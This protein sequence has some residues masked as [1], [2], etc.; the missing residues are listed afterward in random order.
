MIG[1]RITLLGSHEQQLRSWLTG[2]PFGHERGAI[3]LFR[4]LSRP[5]K[6]LPRS[7]R[8]LSVEI[9]ELG[10]DWVLESS[11]TDFTINMRKFPEIYF[12][13]E[14]EQLELGFV[15]SHPD[16]Y[17]DFSPRDDANEKNILHG[18][19]GCNNEKSF[20]VSLILAEGK[21][22]AR[23][24]QGIDPNSILP[25]RHI[26]VVSDMI[27]LHGISAPIDSLENLKRQEAAF[28]KP[29]NLMMQSLRV[30]VIGLGGTGSPTA[31]LLA[32]SGIGELILIDGD[33]LDKT[34]MNRVRGYTSTNIGKRKAESLA[35]FIASL[36]L[37]TSISFINGYLHESEE[38]LDA[39]SSADVV[40]GCTDD[41]AGR[42]ILNQALYYYSQVLIDVGL[43][44]FV[45]KSPD[46]TPYL[47][48]HRGRVSC[49]L[50]EF[51]ACLRC[52]K[53]I[54]DDM[55]K[56]ERALKERPE[57]ANLDPETLQREYYLRG[58]GVGA[59]GI[60]PFT[61]ATA[62][63]GV[64][65]LMNLIKR[66]RD[67]PTDLRADNVWIDFVHLNVHSND[68]TDDPECIHCRTG[69]LLVRQER[70]YRL[71]TPSLGKIPI[72]A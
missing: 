25:V 4:R 2:H 22:S 34:N 18:I 48:D 44:G 38:A 65:T 36:G 23:V 31:T 56:F 41:V 33:I 61:S 8:F 42:D 55:L 28:G 5:V 54:T 32:R 69:L 39:L 45:D 26:C 53:V 58:G 15:H 72:D 47:R 59:P 3:I 20:L 66:F 13:C 63:N 71:D 11:K 52:Q 51:G 30:A 24:R 6:N 1:H 7:D 68:P 67:L 64:A 19:S 40:F 50:P 29:F 57:L 21:W 10:E 49:V 70:T 35:G 9:I 14:S 43:T 46:G 60:G 17:L 37:N 62:D 27:E 12:R 16:G